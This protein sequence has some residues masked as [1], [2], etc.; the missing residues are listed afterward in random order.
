MTTKVENILIL[1]AYGR[2]GED[3]SLFFDKYHSVIRQGRNEDA[4]VYLPDLNVQSLKQV[5]GEFKI[6]A[7]INLIAMTDV[8]DC[9]NMASD[10][11][12]ANAIIPQY[13]RVAVD[14][15]DREIFVL[16]ISTDQIYSGQDIHEEYQVN[17]CNVYGVSKLAG[18]QLINAPTN[19]CILRTN[20]FG[21]S[22]VKNRS[23]FLD[24]IV[25]SIKENQEISI[26]QDVYFT[27]VGSKTLC[28]IISMIIDNRISGTYNFGSNRSISKADFAKIV[29]NTMSV[30]DPLFV[31]ADYPKSSLVNRPRDMSMNSERILSRLSIDSVNIEREVMHELQT[32]NKNN[33]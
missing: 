6:T 15:S 23:S 8:N 30:L 12:I 14:Q 2:L 28:S 4:Q 17:P 11:F 13:I 33:T 25:N 22:R 19:T 18:E 16:H 26:Y 31:L 29:A 10:A 24:W 32:L 7:I 3:L 9:E 5:L 1:G 21:L 27:P 20:Y